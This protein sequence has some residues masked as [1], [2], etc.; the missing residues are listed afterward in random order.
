M[1]VEE[2]RDLL[3]NEFAYIF[4]DIIP[5]IN[6]LKLE[7]T[8]KILDIGTGMGRMAITLALKNYKV[9]TGEPENDETEYAKQDWLESARKVKVDHLITYMPFNAEEMPFEDASFDAI[10]IL[11]ALHH[12]SDIE[13]TLKECFRILRLNGIVCVFEPNSDGIKIIREK[14]FPTHPDAVDPR[15]YVR[16]LHFLS[17]LIKRPFYDTYILRKQ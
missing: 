14:K 17:E 4:N 12:I 8:A 5:V 3:G 7:K 10:F 11:G 13:A 15:N 16:E 6:G 9:I 2:L 1:D